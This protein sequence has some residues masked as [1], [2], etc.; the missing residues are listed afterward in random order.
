[1][2]AFLCH[3]A[4]GPFLFVYFSELGLSGQQVGWLASLFPLMTLL[5][6]TPV[7][8]LADRKHQRVRIAQGAMFGMSI[9][10]YLLH[11]P[12][13]FAGIAG[14]MLLMAIIS[15]PV[16]SLTDSLI[17]RMAHRNH[18]NYG[19]MRLWG[20]VGFATSALIFGALW[21]RLGF[22]PMFLVGSLLFL[23]VIWITGRL[24]E[25]S[26]MGVQKQGAFSELFRDSGLVLLLIATILASIANSLSLT[27]EGI[28]VRS[29]GGGN[30][31][32]GLMVASA[33]YS[34]LPTMFFGDQIAQRIR[35]PNAVIL[36]YG[37]AASA[38]I[39]YILVANPAILPIFSILKGLGF[40]LFFPTTVRII[41]ERTP[42]EW[43]STAQSL[44][45]VG[46]FG[47]APLVAGPIGGFIH[48]AI[49]PGAVFGLGILALGLAAVVLWFATF[50]GNLK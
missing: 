7:S 43:A 34:E 42:D 27:F 15:S 18:L 29:L 30:F 1:M 22:E 8:S 36:A 20:S 10:L 26:G 28:F 38:Y 23:L 17:A 9:I 44:M 16:M 31:L 25:T 40:G 47:V 3:G 11:Y 21:Q 6:A 24:D 37:L 41:T 19:G 35:G 14:L 32:I 45:A 33:A 2:S 13:T 49:S 12:T 4:Y 46:M 50:R 5:L 48:D 39:G